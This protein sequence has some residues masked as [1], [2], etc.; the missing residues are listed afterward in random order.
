MPIYE[1]R[2]L[3][4]GHVFELLKL[5]KETEK[6]KME[7]PKCKSQEV[8]RILSTVSVVTSGGGKKTQTV[9]S[10]GSGSCATIEVPGHSR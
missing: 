6:V 2:C 1:F 8:E 4:C 3:S 7:C 5:K 10:C 9:K